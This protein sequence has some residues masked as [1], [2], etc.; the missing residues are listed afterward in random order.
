MWYYVVSLVVIFIMSCSLVPRCQPLLSYDVLCRSL[1]LSIIMWYSI[2]FHL[3][4]DDPCVVPWFW[5]FYHNISLCLVRI[6][7]YCVVVMTVWIPGTLRQSLCISYTRVQD[8]GGE[9]GE[10]RGEG[11]DGGGRR[12]EESEGFG[13]ENWDYGLLPGSTQIQLTCTVVSATNLMTSTIID[14]P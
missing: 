4:C 5:P 3:W 10:G 6:C 8:G 9:G 14:Q 7:D 11:R 12:E 1:D 2:V 13:W